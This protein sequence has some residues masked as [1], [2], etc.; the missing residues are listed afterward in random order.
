METYMK[1]LK[2]VYYFV[3]LACFGKCMAKAS[4]LE[5]FIETKKFTIQHKF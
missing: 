5:T 3:P 1:F 2:I 4:A